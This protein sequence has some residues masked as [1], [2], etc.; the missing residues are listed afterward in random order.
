MLPMGTVGGPGVSCVAGGAARG[1]GGS[2]CQ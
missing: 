1:S 2:F